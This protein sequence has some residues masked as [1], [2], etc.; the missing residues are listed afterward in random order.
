MDKIETTQEIAA[1]SKVLR[2]ELEYIEDESKMAQMNEEKTREQISAAER[3]LKT[4]FVVAGVFC[5]LFG[6]LVLLSKTAKSYF[7]VMVFSLVKTALPVLTA[8][9]NFGTVQSV[10]SQYWTLIRDKIKY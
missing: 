2:R 5:L 7:S 8:L 6:V 3:S 4:N 9:A 10:L 1:S